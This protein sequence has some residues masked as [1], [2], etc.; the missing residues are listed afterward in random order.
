MTHSGL[1]LTRRWT[2]LLG[3]LSSFVGDIILGFSV[4][5]TLVAKLQVMHFPK[6]PL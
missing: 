4:T 5:A 6:S 1:L 3:E 2:S